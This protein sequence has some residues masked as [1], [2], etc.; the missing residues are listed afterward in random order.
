MSPMTQ[1][2]NM[3]ATTI[4]FFFKNGRSLGGIFPFILMGTFSTLP[5]LLLQHMYISQKRDK[6]KL[7]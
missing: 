2:I 6:H 1:Y 7:F 5:L 3:L 4:T